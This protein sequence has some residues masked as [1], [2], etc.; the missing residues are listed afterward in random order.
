MP[1]VKV[2][3]AGVK[4]AP[5]QVPTETTATILP[6]TVDRVGQETAEDEQPTKVS[7]LAEAFEKFAPKLDFKTSVGEEGTEFAADLEFKSLKDFDPKKLMSKTP[8]KRNDLADLQS[9]IDLLHRMRER[10]SVLS[11]RRAWDNPEQRK[12][13]IEAISQ[14]QDALKKISGGEA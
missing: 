3:R 12:E 11:V 7:S 2:T 8:G 9:Q 5:R 1:V 4:M 14:F 6:M 13:I 10:F